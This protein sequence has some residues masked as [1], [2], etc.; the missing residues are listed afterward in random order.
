[1]VCDRRAAVAVYSLRRLA[2]STKDALA[3]SERLAKS[4]A[5]LVSLSERIDTM[6]NAGRQKATVK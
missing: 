2:R 3:V 5:D 4:G 6:T 1:M